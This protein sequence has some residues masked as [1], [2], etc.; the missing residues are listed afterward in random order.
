[1][2]GPEREGIRTNQLHRL[3]NRMTTVAE[4]G[5][6][7]VPSGGRSDDRRRRA[8]ERSR[9]DRAGYGRQTTKR[10]RSTAAHRSVIERERVVAEGNEVEEEVARL[11]GYKS[12]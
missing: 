4:R 1:M 12:P 6:P 5:T 8:V 11:V 10:R 9:R 3:E 2:S 7:V